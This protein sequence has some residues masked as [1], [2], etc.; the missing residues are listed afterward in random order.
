MTFL[1][2]KSRIWEI[3]LLME[4]KV[5]AMETGILLNEPGI[6]LKVGIQDPLSTQRIRH[7]LPGMRNPRLS[8]ILFNTWA[9]RIVGKNG[10]EEGKICPLTDMFSIFSLLA[11]HPKISKSFN[12]Y[13]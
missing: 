10:N 13:L 7:P 1:L 6:T 4:S 9:I 11:C 8:W 5:W 3:F 12:K 2:V